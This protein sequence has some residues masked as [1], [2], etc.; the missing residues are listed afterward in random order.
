[1]KP[2]PGPNQILRKSKSK[3]K[4]A[5]RSGKPSKSV[6]QSKAPLEPGA[7]SKPKRRH[8]E[9]TEAHKSGKSPSVSSSDVSRAID[10][11]IR[12]L[13]GWRAK[14][15]ARMRALI[16]E[17]DPEVIEELKWMETPVWSRN[18]ILCTGEVYTKV[19]KLT[20]ARGARVPDPSRLFNSSL[21]GNTRR[22]I[23]KR[24]GELVD[25]DAFKALVKAAV[26]QNA[27]QAKER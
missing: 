3:S 10:R 19:V 20:F 4:E 9:P 23:D 24:E 18:G 14:T 16:L 6:V 8:A 5:P 17:A 1:M 22:A 7:S 13:G 27:A 25:A 21:D 11:Q 15:L 26:A 2:R 12:E